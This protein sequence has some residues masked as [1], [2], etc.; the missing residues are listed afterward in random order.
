MTRPTMTRIALAVG[1]LITLA[2]RSCPA[3]LSLRFQPPL[4]P[5]PSPDG[6]GYFDLVFTETQPTENEGLFA[7]DLG[8]VVPQS[9]RG[10]ISL[11]GAERPTSNFV[12]DVPSGATFTVAES[13]ANHVLVNVASNNDLADINSG[14][15]AARVFYRV[16]GCF[17]QSLEI[18]LDPGST[19]FGSGD[20]NR[21][22]EITVNLSDSGYIPPC[23]EPGGL[24][25]L[26]GAAVI[27]LRRVRR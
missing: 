24:A 23:P 25:L 16:E 15:V 10:K 27:A 20:P 22:L 19:V 4:F 14:D 6:R 21:D 5:Q 17:M 2:P 3:A 12:L 18:T 7:Y 8:L 26:A 13:D 1:C 9:D 11:L